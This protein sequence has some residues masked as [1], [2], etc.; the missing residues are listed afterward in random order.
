M[1]NLSPQSVTANVKKMNL[2]SLDR[3]DLPSGQRLIR[4]WLIAFVLL[5]I[6]ILFMPWRQNFRAKG[7]VTSRDAADRPQS[8]HSTIPGRIEAWLHF[9]GDTVRKGDVI[10][11]VSEIKSDYFDPQLVERTGEIREAKEGSAGGYLAKANALTNQ[12]I[13]LREEQALKLEES[14]NKLEQSRLYVSTLA[15][16]LVQQQTQVDIAVFQEA[17]TDSLFNSGLKSLT[18]LEAKRLKRQEAQAKLIATQNKLEQARTDVEQARIALAA[19]NPNYAGKIAKAESDRQSALTSY[20]TAV[21]DVTKLEST[22]ANYRIRREFNAITAPQDGVIGKILTPGIGETVK[23]GEAIATILPAT[24]I[25]A[26]E[27]YVE[28]FNLPLVAIGQEVRFLFDGWPAVFFSGWPGLSYGTFKGE[29][30]AIDNT[31]DSK[32]RYRVLVAPSL[33]D[34][35]RPWPAALRPGSGAEGVALLGEVRVWYEV[36][37]QLNAFPPDYYKDDRYVDDPEKGLKVKAPAKTVVK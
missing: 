34:G 27:M 9:E 14:Q 19:V 18:D 6:I 35:G 24:F 29:V 7:T 1:L 36:W 13:A 15:A 33:E 22:E 26:V 3:V 16:D 17:R 31:I 30:V 28:P 5:S 21:G 11:R 4:R 2:S 8:V 10:A 23:E 37:R 25:P 20:Y 12:I 32:G